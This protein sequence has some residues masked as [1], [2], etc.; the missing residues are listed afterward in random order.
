MLVYIFI[1]K[2]LFIFICVLKFSSRRF[3]KILFVGFFG[4]S[5]IVIMIGNGDKIME[6]LIML[7]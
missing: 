5:F 1:N 4:I 7:I 3:N 6:K 2:R